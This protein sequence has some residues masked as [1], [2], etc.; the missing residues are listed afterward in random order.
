MTIKFSHD[1]WPHPSSKSEQRHSVPQIIQLSAQK[2]EHV[3]GPKKSHKICNRTC[4]PQ[5]NSTKSCIYLIANRS[6]VQIVLEIIHE[7]TLKKGFRNSLSRNNICA[8]SPGFTMTL[9]NFI[10]CDVV[11]R[12]KAYTLTTWRLMVSRLVVLFFLQFSC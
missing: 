10:G 8:I 4:N 9:P 12:W 5:E 2:R 11:G 6:R 3:H 7:L 1:H